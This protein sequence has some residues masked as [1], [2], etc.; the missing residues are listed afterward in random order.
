MRERK[1]RA[2]ARSSSFRNNESLRAIYRYI[3]M[4]NIKAGRN[5]E[6]S[7]AKRRTAHNY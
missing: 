3:Y 2:S 4:Y 7:N 5:K 6:Q 1:A